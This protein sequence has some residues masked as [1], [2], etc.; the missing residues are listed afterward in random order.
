[1]AGCLPGVVHGEDVGVIERGRDLDLAQEALG[2]DR[3]AEIRSEHFDG[4]LAVVLQVQGEM[5]RGHP[6]LAQRA[7][8]AVAVG[9]RLRKLLVVRYHRLNMRPVATA[10]PPAD[11]LAALLR[12]PHVPVAVNV[13]LP[14]E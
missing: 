4:Y 11:Q 1:K 10:R 14:K 13:L 3:S 6:P 7:L 2:P 9:Q 5:N 8:Q 12:S